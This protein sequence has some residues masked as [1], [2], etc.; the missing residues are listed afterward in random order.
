MVKARFIPASFWLGRDPEVIAIWLL[1]YAC[2]PSDSL[3]TGEDA[4]AH[5]PG[6]RCSGLSGA[7]EGSSSPGF[8]R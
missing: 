7:V 5:R 2:I 1:D 3:R 6:S 4:H 8:S